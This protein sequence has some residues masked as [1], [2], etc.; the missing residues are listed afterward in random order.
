MHTPNVGQAYV[1]KVCSKLANMKK[2]VLVLIGFLISVIGFSQTYVSGFL[3]TNTIWDSINDPYIVTG[4]LLVTDSVKLTILPGTVV[5]LDGQKAIQIDGEINVLGSDSSRVTFTTNNSGY[6]DAIIISPSSQSSLFDSVGNYLSG[7]IIQ[8]A[9]LNFGGYVQAGNTNSAMIECN[10]TTLFLENCLFSNSASEGIWF[11]GNSS[12][13]QS[14]VINNNFFS[15]G[16]TFQMNGNPKKIISNHINNGRIWLVNYSGNAIIESNVIKNTTY[17]IRSHVSDNTQILNNVVLTIGGSTSSGITQN[18]HTNQNSYTIH[19]NIIIGDCNNSFASSISNNVFIGNFNPIKTSVYNSYLSLF[20]NNQFIE[21]ENNSS[22]DNYPMIE[23][24]N[25]GYNASYKFSHNLFEEN[26]VPNYM[27]IIQHR[28]DYNLNI[29]LNNN[30]F[31]NNQGSYLVKNLNTSFDI[32]AYDN[33]WGTTSTSVINQS[34]YDWFDNPVKSFV[35]YTPILTSPD[36]TAPISRPRG[37]QLIESCN[38][39]IL[40]YN[41]NLELDT[42]GYKI[43]YGN[44]NGY[45]FEYSIDLGDTNIFDTQLLSAYGTIA[46]TAYDNLADGINDLTEGHESWYRFVN[47]NSVTKQLDLSNFNSNT[48]QWGD[49]ILLVADSNYTSYLW[50][51]LD[52]TN[53]IYVTSPG[54]YSLVVTDSNG[55]S[56]CDTVTINLATDIIENNLEKTFTIYPNPTTNKLSII[57]NHLDIIE[58]NIIDLAGR[59]MKTVNQNLHTINVTDL[60]NGI[61]FIKLLTDEKTIIK[62]FIKQ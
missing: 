3:T 60:P 26:Q 35:L 55:I 4:N 58:I 2:I 21:C 39:P 10:S 33:Y 38:E 48:F 17:G 12:N 46:I 50:S 18:K 20:T 24:N 37:I 51:T 52:T 25:P 54:T 59:H 45:E 1:L 34:I 44:F 5:R 28:N 6:W 30:N 42:K 11:N 47:L 62:K 43:Y 22:N 9:D 31:I 56:Y 57:G 61:Y 32:P 29:S 14:L 16:I 49:T 8:N 13:G 23:L 7:N 41:S 15:C 19:G 40:F 36:T 53:S 27:G